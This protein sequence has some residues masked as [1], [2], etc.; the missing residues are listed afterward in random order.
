MTQTAAPTA[1]QTFEFSG[2]DSY[3]R[4]SYTIYAARPDAQYGQ[5]VAITVLPK[6]A[7]EADG[8][9]HMVTDNRREMPFTKNFQADRV[10]VVKGLAAARAEADRI[11]KL[12]AGTPAF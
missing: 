11:A 4:T 8:A 2:R 10:R 12:P 1:T 6:M 5:V 3:G 9:R 7:A